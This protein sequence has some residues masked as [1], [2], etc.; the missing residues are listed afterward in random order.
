VG[1]DI[2]TSTFKAGLFQRDGRC[3]RRSAQ[4]LP[5]ESS[6]GRYEADPAQWLRAFTAALDSLG[7][8]AAVR[9]LAVSGNGPTLVP[10]IGTPSLAG[11]ELR[12]P[13]EQARLWLDRRAQA[14]SQTI[15]AIAGGFVDPS[16]VLPKALFI[17]NRENALYER[18]RY[19]FSSSEYLAYALTGEARTVFPSAGF[20][21]WYWNDRTLEAAGLAKEKFPPFVFPGE[22]IGRVSKAASAR[23][24]FPPDLRVFAGGP[25][26]FAA[27]LGTG[28]IR[29][30]QTCDRSGT[31]EGV[32]VCTQDRIVDPRLMSYGHPA[33]PFWNCSGIIATSGKA[34]SWGRSVGGMEALPYRAFYG[35]AASAAA[36]AGGV[37]FLPYLA[38]ERSPIWDSRARGAFL[39]LDLNTRRAELARAVAEGVCFAIRDVL[40]V[41]RDLGAGVSELR[42]TGGPAESSF[43]NQL[44][45]DI[46][47]LPVLRPRMPEA[48]LLGL[49]AISAAALG[50]YASAAEAAE[51]LVEIGDRFYPQEALASRYDRLFGVY[52]GAYQALKGQFEALSRL[53]E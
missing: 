46:C 6:G 41:I 20:D 26:F 35:L 29:P 21:R 5:I 4:P 8:L 40:S 31:S 14:E 24:G 18:T 33:K 11:G 37:V 52:R 53:A 13:A 23:F 10:V 32:N 49:T 42:V 2:G 22:L 17:K 7:S 12:V 16:F 34:L 48:E 44:K 25:D 30:G 9:A 28:T 45:A 3:I 43:L 51:Q 47:G 19:F 1:I 15:S 38:G 50:I 27:I 36:G 39:G